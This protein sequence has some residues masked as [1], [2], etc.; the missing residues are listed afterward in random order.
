[1]QTTYIFFILMIFVSFACEHSASTGP[2]PTQ[3]GTPTT[4]TKIQSDIFTPNC[5]LSGCHGDTQNP[6]LNAGQAYDNIV[7]VVSSQGIDYIEPGDPA[8]SYLY[9]KITG[10]GIIGTRMPRNAS[11][12]SAAV[13]DSVRSWIERGAPNN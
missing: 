6:R 5:A 11:P 10:T 13:I 9:K 8:N 2:D 4:F 7:N 3:N 12:L 1:M